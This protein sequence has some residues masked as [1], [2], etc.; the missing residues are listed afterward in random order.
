MKKALKIFNA[1]M[2]VLLVIVLVFSIGLLYS[3][4]IKK[5]GLP[6]SF[7]YSYAVV[8]S[9]SMSPAIKTGE[10]VVIK[11]ND[12]YVVDD[13][14]TYESNGI[15]ITHRIISVTRTGYI[16]KGDANNIPDG[17]I[18]ASRVCGRVIYHSMKLGRAF[19]FISSPFG[20][21]CIIIIAALLWWIPKKIKPSDK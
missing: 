18:S 15:Y 10:L 11:R 14:V 3:K 21:L 13:I 5:D 19:D 2:S 6:Q 9:G 4:I 16:T 8:A 12:S 1:V 7:G 20:A 17:E